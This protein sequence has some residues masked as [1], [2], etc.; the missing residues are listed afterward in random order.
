MIMTEQE[1]AFCAHFEQ[2]MLPNKYRITANMIGESGAIIG[3][4]FRLNCQSCLHDAAIDLMNIY[5][6][7]V[8]AAFPGAWNSEIEFKD[9]YHKPIEEPIHTKYEETILET[10]ATKQEK[11]QIPGPKLGI[12]EP[13]A[14][15]K[16]PIK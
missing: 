2:V 4:S 7:I 8:E 12:S 11:P 9:E 16:K 15:K 13:V 3:K 14:T 1:K 6:K 10:V 5:N